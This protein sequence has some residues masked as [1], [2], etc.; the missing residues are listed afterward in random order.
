MTFI[1]SNIIIPLFKKEDESKNMALTFFKNLNQQYL[2][3]GICLLELRFIL[4]KYTMK[5]EDI[6]KAV[7]A[8]FSFKELKFLPITPEN[9]ENSFKYIRKNKLG[10][11]DSVILATMVETRDFAIIS[12]DTDFD[13]VR[14][15][16]RRSLKDMV[17]EYPSEEK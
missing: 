4:R 14:F 15:I 17:L 5:D 12:E 16:Q 10:F 9:I 13:K 8:L 11:F 6:E 3:S 2:V 1:D 7:N